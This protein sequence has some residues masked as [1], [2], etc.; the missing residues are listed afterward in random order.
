[1]SARAIRSLLL[2]FNVGDLD[3]NPF[4]EGFLQDSLID[5]SFKDCLAE[6]TKSVV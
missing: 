4:S 1:M 6:E 5:A 2:L 3:K